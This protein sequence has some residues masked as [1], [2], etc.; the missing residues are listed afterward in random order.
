MMR[1]LTTSGR[2]MG[3]PSLAQT[4][5]K[6]GAGMLK[7]GISDAKILAFNKRHNFLEGIAA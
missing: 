2:R 3:H 5:K 1:L 6:P 7:H 4:A